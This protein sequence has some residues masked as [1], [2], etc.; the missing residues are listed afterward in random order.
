MRSSDAGRNSSVSPR[1]RNRARGEVRVVALVL[2]VDEVAQHPSRRYGPPV[3]QPE[4]GRA[5]VDRRADAVD[6]ADRGDD[7]DVPALEQRVGGGVPEPVDLV[8]ARRV[9]LDVR[10]APGQVRLGLVVVEVAD[11]VLDRVVREEVPELGVQ[12]R[13]ERLVVGEDER[14][15]VG[16]LDRPWRS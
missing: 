1:T 6:A 7:D 4:D 3:A 10:V 11:E 2:Q 15:A 12:L 9:L 5:V 14:R 13:R 16:G 8:V